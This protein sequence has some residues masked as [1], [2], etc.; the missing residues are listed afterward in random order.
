MPVVS[1]KSDKQSA[2]LKLY[3][4]KLRHFLSSLAEH[5][6]KF[7]LYHEKRRKN[8]QEIARASE[9]YAEIKERRE[10]AKKEK[11]EKERLK[12]LKA[13]DTEAYLTL[14]KEHKN[15]KLIAVLRETDSY[16]KSLGSK[17]QMQKV[18]PRP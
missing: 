5:R 4:A 2:R 13:N 7:M 11:M 9:K 6:D 12:A 3:N 1:N 18:E 10:R 16:L 8:L 14:L 15:E 17:V